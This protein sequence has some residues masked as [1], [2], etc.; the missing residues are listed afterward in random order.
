MKTTSELRSFGLNIFIACGTFIYIQLQL[1][2]GFV[3]PL[4]ESVKIS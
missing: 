3:Y 1:K 2:G 4:G